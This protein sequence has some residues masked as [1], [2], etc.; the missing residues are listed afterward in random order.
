MPRTD[1]PFP[2][3]IEKTQEC[4][5]RELRELRD[6]R[7]KQEAWAASHMPGQAARL[8]SDSD[9]LAELFRYHQPT[10]ET[11]PKYVAIN[12]AAKNFAEIVLQNCPSGKDRSKVIGLIQDAR[13][14]ANRA[15]ALNGL[16]L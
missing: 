13:M 5:P 2:G 6:L 4:E 11:L 9:I 8:M 14:T 3:D 15:V 16:S 1:I 12:Q 7:E 10:E